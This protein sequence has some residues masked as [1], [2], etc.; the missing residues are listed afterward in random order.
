MTDGRPVL[1]LLLTSCFLRARSF[2]QDLQ[3]I[4][5]LDDPGDFPALT[6]DR[7]APP[8]LR[9]QTMTRVNRVLFVTARDHV[10]AVNLSTAAEAFVPQMTLTWRPSDVSKCA[11]RGM[12]GDECYNYIKV[13]APRDDETLLV[14]GTNAFN[15]ACRIYKTSTLE[16]VGSDLPGQARCPFRS[17]Q[18]SAGTFA[19]GAF[20]SATVTDFLASDAVI[21]R[22]GLG[23][24]PAVLRTVKYDSKWLREPRFLHAVDYGSYVYFF[25]S[26][27]ASEYTALGKV[28]FSRVARVCKNDDG[29]PP[30]L[31]HKHWTSF[32]KARLNCSLPGDSLFYFDVL[33]SLSGVV[34]IN[35]RPAVLAVFTTQANSIPGSA[36]CA[37]YMDE[38]DDVFGGKF[39]EQRAGDSAWTPVPERAVPTPRPGACAGEGTASALKSSLDFPDETLAFVKSFPL[40][41]GAVPAANRRPFYTRTAGRSRLT[42]M[43]ADVWAGPSKDRTV[44]F[45]GSED[46][47]V[48]KVLADRAAGSKLLEDIHVYDPNR[49]DVGVG[50][51]D[52]RVL[53]LQ[54]DKEH[55]ALFVA[56]R[57]CLLR[58]PLSRCRRHGACKRSC[59][60]SGDP[61]CIWLRTG[62]CADAAPG[63]KA[64]FEQDVEGDLSNM[65]ACH[66]D[67]PA[68]SRDRDVPPADSAY[69]VRV[70]DA[71]ADGADADPPSGVHYTLL[72]ACTLLAFSLGAA[73][74]GLA[75]SRCGGRDA[76]RQ[77][78]FAKEAEASLPR[79][80][81]PHAPAGPGGLPDP[82]PK[83]ERSADWPCPK[84]YASFIPGGPPAAAVTAVTASRPLPAVEPQAAREPPT[85]SPELPDGEQSSERRPAG[86]PA[87][88]PLAAERST[89]PPHPGGDVSAL[90][91]LLRHIQQVSAHGD[92]GI[93]VLTTAPADRHH[94]HHHH[95]HQSGKMRANGHHHGNHALALNANGAISRPAAIPEAAV[96]PRGPALITMAGG[97]PRHHSF[98]QRG[99]P[100]RSHFLARMNSNDGAGQPARRQRAPPPS[101][102][103]TCLT[104]Q[105]SYSEGARVRRANAGVGVRRAVSLKP[106][107]PPKPKHL[108][109][110]DVSAPQGQF[111]C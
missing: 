15:P 93:R 25:L 72:L 48:A 64:G 11:V 28:V 82:A 69:G 99:A 89:P 78:A 50:R 75:V 108:F 70:A 102:S 39:K 62:T 61:Y 27:I 5:V 10:F 106:K 100:P 23:D 34:Q 58:V 94:H 1:L 55:H 111:G 4:S 21:Y 92:G 49:C 80:L 32:L 33:Q 98:N 3:A 105:H 20:Y 109:A 86:G 56:F 43:A 65:A 54:L 59:L 84:T 45:L 18:S 66:A 40:M 53:S 19:G 103:G 26:E 87:P 77:G 47:R 90:D 14:C 17:G 83:E 95:H 96:W 42:Q 63:F 2:P 46:G 101:A 38:V 85:A 104:R 74:S 29:G 16:Q 30:R 71:A 37:F 76:R 31:L 12:D 35:R 52:R 97:L 7:T 24:G 6:I 41:D 60:A 51:P 36:V 91:E 9:F 57:G 13:L 107:V 88:A 22:S 81:T 73:L 110:P 8:D 67:V 79:A 44:L 68:T